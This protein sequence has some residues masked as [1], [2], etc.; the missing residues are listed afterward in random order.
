MINNC[1]NTL[2]LY[3]KKFIMICKLQKTLPTMKMFVTYMDDKINI[4]KQ[5][6][7]KHMEKYNVCLDFINSVDL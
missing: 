3:G 7:C 5:T 2:F 4:V 1:R 6:H